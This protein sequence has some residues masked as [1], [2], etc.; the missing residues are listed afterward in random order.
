MG[1]SVIAIHQSLCLFEKYRA[2]VLS[3]ADV[4]VAW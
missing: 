1:E 4:V 3:F 2:F